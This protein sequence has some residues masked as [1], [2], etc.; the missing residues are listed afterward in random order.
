LTV[1]LD[2]AMTAED[3]GESVGEIIDLKVDNRELVVD[4]LYKSNTVKP[5]AVLNSHQEAYQELDADHCL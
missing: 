2:G 4:A 1:S 3:F 5:E